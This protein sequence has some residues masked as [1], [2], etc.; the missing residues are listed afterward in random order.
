MNNRAIC[1]RAKV[2]Y[3]ATD[4]RTRKCGKKKNCH[5]PAPAVLQPK[6]A[7]RF[8]IFFFSSHII[9]FT[10]FY[11]IVYMY[12]SRC[13]MDTRAANNGRKTEFTRTQPQKYAHV[14]FTDT[15]GSRTAVYAPSSIFS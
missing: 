8:R 9:V 4:V 1:D 10:F 13:V 14:T 11:F 12:E 7:S 3:C 6:W 15:N 2:R 5:T